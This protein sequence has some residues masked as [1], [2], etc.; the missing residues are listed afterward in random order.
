VREGEHTPGSGKLPF[1]S[2]IVPVL[3][4]PR[5]L[6]RCLEALERQSYPSEAYEVLVVDNGS[7]EPVEP[8]LRDYQQATGLVEARR[9]S[10]AARNRALEAAKGEILAFI[11]ADCLPVPQWLEEGVALLESE[12]A[13]L[14]GGAVEFTY[15]PRA[16]AAEL[17][18]SVTSM[19]IE[20]NIRGRKVAKTANLFVRRRVVDDIGPFPDH[21]R[22]GGDVLWTR[23]ATERGH[24]LLYAPRA[25]VQHPARRLR[26]LMG[27]QYRVGVGQATIWR[28]EEISLRTRL[29]RLL[30]AFLPVRPGE[31][32]SRLARLREGSPSRGIFSLWL[33]AWLA[34]AFAGIGNLAGL[35]SSP[36]ARRSAAR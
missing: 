25:V 30:S 19:Q 9:G 32:R 4:D 28:E 18:D 27:K 20:E 12:R 6:L 21:L 10:Y 15:S 29:G 23:R 22:S 2:V 14:A 34:D 36:G 31:I 33:V 26:G 8:L 35:L 7:R 16:A 3:D 11:D 13:D 17:Y 24:T 5:H 1:V